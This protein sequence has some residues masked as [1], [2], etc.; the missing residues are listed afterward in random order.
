MRVG[1][2]SRPDGQGEAGGAAILVAILASVLVG[3]AAISVDVGRLFWEKGQLQNGA[4]TAALSVAQFCAK[5]GCAQAEA[6]ALAAQLANDNSN[7]AKSNANVTLDT[8]IGRV[9]VD[10]SA[11]EDGASANSVSLFFA[12]IFGYS[13]AVVGARAVARWGGPTAL[14]AKFPLAFSACEIDASMTADGSLQVLLS[15]GLNQVNA[16][17]ACHDT[18]SG[19]E[20]PGGFGWL[21]QEPAGSCNTSTFIG[22]WELNDTG[23]N[24]PPNCLSILSDWKAKISS[25]Q[26]V[27]ALLPVFNATKDGKQYQISQYAAVEIHGWH[28]VNNDPILDFLPPDAAAVMAP[29]VYKN[30]DLGFVAKFIRYV[31]TDEDANVDPTPSPNGANVANLT[32]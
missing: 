13:D 31:F 4:D 23:N 17:D 1:C 20:I 10:T 5:S 6:D 30:S 16:S 22:S 19:Q 27:V 28:F 12:R 11:Q 21:V 15:H 18:A 24:F 26:Q 14:T 8:S 25:G 9:Q 3:F 7:D 32:Q 29:P 2:R